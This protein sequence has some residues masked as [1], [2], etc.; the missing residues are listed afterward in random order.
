MDSGRPHA[1]NRSSA[2]LRPRRGELAH[3]EFLEAIDAIPEGFVIYDRDDRLLV[4]NRAFRELNIDIADL[5][6]PGVSFAD[7][8]RGRVTR[9]GQGSGGGASCGIDCGPRCR[10]WTLCRAQVHAEPR[11]VMFE[12]TITGRWVRIDEHRTPSGLRVGL[13]TDLSDV[14]DAQTQLARSEAKFR[15][16]YATAPI[17]IVRTS[18]DGRIHDANPTFA[19]ITGS[20]P[21]DSRR[22][23]ELF[24]PRDR[25]A[26][27]EDMAAAGRVGAFGPVERRLVGP[28]GGA[29]T[30]LVQGA[31]VTDTAG[32]TSLWSFLQDISDRKRME[33]RV[34]HAA[35]HDGLTGLPNRSGLSLRLGAEDRRGPG[36]RLGLLL[37]DLDNF[38]VVNDSLG[39]EAGDVLLQA[40][41][42]RLAG[43]MRAGDFVA[44]L[45]GDEFAVLVGEV[46]D[47]RGLEAFAR[48]LF[49]RLGE[50]I[51]HRG[52]PI[53]VGA[54]IGMA[55]APDRSFDPNELLRWADMALYEAKRAGRNRLALFTP[56]M[57]E[58]NRRRYEVVAA[59]RRALDEDR[60][61]P[62]YQPI[63]DLEAGTLCGFE[64][65]CRIVGEEGLDIRPTEIFAH[66]EIAGAVDVRMLERVC[67][68]LVCWRDRGLDDVPVSLNVCDAEFW[69][70]GFGERLCS[71]LERRGLPMERLSIE[72]TESAFLTEDV[73]DLVPILEGLR[74][75]GISSALD[76]FGTGY[77]SL[78]H[79]KSLPIDRVKVDRS[80][81]VDVVFDLS[82][83]VIVDSLVRLGHGLGKQIVAEGIETEAQRRT[84]VELGCRFGQGFLLGYPM[85]S[86][87]V[88][89]RWGGGGDPSVRRRVV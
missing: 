85:S 44:R 69:R 41:A 75:R 42:A 23:P 36:D 52:R 45:G 60:V 1:S 47:E 82:S 40:V 22:L 70:D 15:A 73:R 48:R 66:P 32:V 30:L 8:I 34:W 76:D 49:D 61:V 2:S 89:E 58:A 13:R 55:L 11:G 56:A 54:S 12:T 84:L 31:A 59:T 86:A 46:E 6:E 24:D 33:A 10:D 43:A 78:T 7:L 87:D 65:L 72:V 35:H 62:F 88:V 81:V 71:E 80:F 26:V 74:Q 18:I 14:R 83:R 38:K 64:A 53:R 79:L 16:L 3:A 68:D 37:I 27:E 28:D 25:A 51:S 63:V 77:A 20:G 67:D 29:I 21:G 4:C 39:H 50:E 57:E 9:C 19:V 17:G 5:L